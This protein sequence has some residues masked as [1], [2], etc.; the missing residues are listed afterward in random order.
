MAL[1]RGRYGAEPALLATIYVISPS[2]DVASFRPASVRAYSTSHLASLLRELPTLQQPLA[3]KSH[4]GVLEVTLSVEATRFH[5]GPIAFNSRSYNGMFPGPTLC[6]KPGDLL[7]ITLINQLEP[8]LPSEHLHMNTFRDPNTTN[9]HFHGMHVSP[10]GIAD[11]VLRTVKSGESMEL[12]VKIPE[13][14]PLGVFHYHPHHHGSTFLQMGGGMVGAISVQ[15]TLDH[16]D[17]L[18]ILQAFAF[19]GG[20]LAN[21]VNA[22]HISRST[23]PLDAKLTAR[24]PERMAAV[25]PDYQPRMSGVPG[26][27][28]SFYVVN[29]QYQPRMTL[30]DGERKLF[31]VMN[32]GPTQILELSVPGCDVE[33]HAK[34]AFPPAISTPDYIILTPGARV[35]LS[36]VCHLNGAKSGVFPFVSM[37]HSESQEYMGR[38]TDVYHGVLGLFEVYA[39][40][41][42]SPF[43]PPHVKRGK[44]LM[45]ITHEDEHIERFHITFSSGPATLRDGTMYKSYFMNDRLFSV[46]H[47]YKMKLNVL[48]E[49]TLENVL[50][51]DE[52]NHPFHLHSNPFQIVAMTHG[53][54]LDYSVGDWRDT[55]TLP[56][57][58]NVTIRFRPLDF[59]GLVAAH[60]HIL[61]HA[62][63][64][65][66]LLVEI[67][68]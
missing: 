9:L 7:R 26:D 57:G 34:D 24:S 66:A 32:A 30:S 25:F 68:P 1:P 14:H 3:Y 60:C 41:G 5:D 53:H 13:N 63:V 65:M 61:G 67:Q 16:V 44:N 6:A 23:M 12:V 37:P 50:S 55:I 11:N 21:L 22:T 48:H 39:S 33:V 49:W 8:D 27:Y 58:G 20:M 64:G 31:Q 2:S 29:G 38:L 54:G 43:T 19:R 62:D 56:Y 15:E 45:P 10:S 47:R 51:P 52:K 36:I 59:T 18:L 42:A 28:P 40:N 17:T 35:A 4:N 46:D